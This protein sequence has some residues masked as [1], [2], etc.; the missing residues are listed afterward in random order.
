MRWRYGYQ[1]LSV[2]GPTSSGKTRPDYDFLAF[3][4]SKPQIAD[5]YIEVV[6]VDIFKPSP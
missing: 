6:A 5:M 2:L 1:D 3:P 4:A